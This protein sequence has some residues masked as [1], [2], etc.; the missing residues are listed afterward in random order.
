MRFPIDIRGRSFI[1]FGERL[2]TGVGCRIEAEFVG[3][4]HEQKTKIFFG[5]NIQINDYVHITAAKKITF[6]DNVLIASKVYISDCSHGSYGFE[7]H[8]DSPLSIPKDRKTF[9]DEVKIGDNVWLGENVAVLMGVEI[10]SGSIIGANS[11]VTKSLPANCIAAGIPAKV[12][13]K[14]DFDLNQWRKV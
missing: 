3:N 6:G 1:D 14:F 8:H 12:I 10:G 5:R 7:G 4:E 9:A 13:K 11:V 2:T